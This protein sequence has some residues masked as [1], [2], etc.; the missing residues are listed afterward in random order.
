MTDRKH[1]NIVQ[2]KAA[3]KNTSAV[4]GENVDAQFAGLQEMVA[5]GNVRNMFIVALLNDG[6]IASVWANSSE[7]FVMLGGVENTKHD[8]IHKTIEQRN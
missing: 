1:L 7:P 8:F 5:S 4:N 3:D 2:F 6:G